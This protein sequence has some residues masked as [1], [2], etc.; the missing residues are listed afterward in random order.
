MITILKHAKKAYKDFKIESI[1]KAILS[2]PYLLDGAKIFSDQFNFIRVT[3]FNR[4]NEGI[5]YD[6]ISREDFEIILKDI[7]KGNY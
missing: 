4:T 5:Y 6:E 7:K 3:E 2:D 1:K